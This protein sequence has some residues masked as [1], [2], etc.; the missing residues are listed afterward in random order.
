MT[1]QRPT[2]LEDFML[3]IYVQR[4]A[5]LFPRSASCNPVDPPHKRLPRQC[6]THG[7]REH[8]ARLT[9]DIARKSKL[10]QQFSTKMRGWISCMAAKSSPACQGVGK[11]ALDLFCAG[12]FWAT[13]SKTNERPKKKCEIQDSDLSK[14]NCESGSCV[15]A[16]FEILVVDFAAL[17]VC[18]C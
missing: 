13:H 2:V 16:E 14:Q 1:R 12:S 10:S 15:A 18:S 8:T 5:G 9:T 7:M 11:A 17:R 4:L 6:A 3:I